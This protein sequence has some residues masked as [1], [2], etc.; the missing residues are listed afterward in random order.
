MLRV[1]TIRLELPLK[2]KNQYLL[3]EKGYAGELHFDRELQD[4]HDDFFILN[5]L[6]LE[7][8]N[9]HFQIDTLLI[10]GSTLFVFEVKNYEGDYYIENERW[11]SLLSKTEIEKSPSSAAAM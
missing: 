7:S 8:S 10:N 5:D 6:L 9:T 2:D 11:Y 4:L 3:L 1:L